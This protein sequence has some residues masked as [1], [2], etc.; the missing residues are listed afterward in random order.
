MHS[1]L[2][3]ALRPGTREELKVC[4]VHRDVV[5]GLIKKCYSEEFKQIVPCY[6]LSH[7]LLLC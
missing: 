5:E 4:T 2:Y 6:R 3:A 1:G 7:Y